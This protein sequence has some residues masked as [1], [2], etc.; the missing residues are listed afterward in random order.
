MLLEAEDTD[1][2]E[3]YCHCSA[4]HLVQYEPVGRFY[5]AVVKRQRL[6]KSVSGFDD[7]DEDVTEKASDEKEEKLM[8]LSLEDKQF[9]LTLDSAEWKKQDHYRVLRIPHLRAKATDDDIKKAYRKLMLKYHPDK[10]KQDAALDIPSDLDLHDYFACI[11]RAFEQLSI[12]ESRQSFD[13]VDPTF[14]DATP[15]TFNANKQDFFKVFEPVFERNSRWSNTQ[16]VPKL[17]DMTLTIDEI[18]EFYTFWFEF[19]SWRNFSYQDEEDTEK[20]ESR[21]ERRWMERENKSKRT[22]KKKEEMSRIKSFVELAYQNDPRIKKYKEEEKRKRMDI[23][24][25]KEAAAAEEKRKRLE[26]LENEKKAKE[27]A[28]REAKEKAL[29]EKKEKDKLKKAAA[30]DRK[31]IRQFVKSENYFSIDK[32]DVASLERLEKSL[33]NL[34]LENVQTLKTLV[35]TKNKEEFK[36]QYIEYSNDVLKKLQEEAERRKQEELERAKASKQAT[37]SNQGASAVWSDL[38][39]QL[40]VKATTLFPIGTAS[41]WEVIAGYINEHGQNTGNEKN[42]KQVINKVKSLKKQDASLK[43]EINKKAFSVLEQATTAKQNAPSANKIVSN[44]TVKD[45]GKEKE[46]VPPMAP[47]SSNEQKLLE[48][49]LKK[50]DSKTPERWDKIAGDVGTR[51]KKECMKRYKELVEMVKAKKAAAGQ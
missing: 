28:E 41:R 25:A 7:V 43:E 12:L 37:T 36:K 33:E 40:L 1:K 50:Y 35:D 14:D 10:R 47:W 31:S 29:K 11:T 45:E 19:S 22:K 27:Q 38:E 2:T 42:G 34:S 44:V 13:S 16:P 51:T 23:K 18:N 39:L 15:T 8:E 48:Q 9:L 21:E 17:G 20:A 4:L 6:D 3:V 32:D 26:A 24:K 30:K 49:A 46:P 5:E